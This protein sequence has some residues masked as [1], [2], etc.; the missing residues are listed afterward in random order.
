[1]LTELPVEA[2]ILYLKITAHGQDYSF[3]FGENT[4]N[5]QTLLENVDGRILS[6][7]VAGGFVGTEIGLYASSNGD[8]S[9]NKAYFDWFEYVGG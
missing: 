4:S 9:K 7:D 2:S 3:Y 8:R 5:Y 6:T 1:M